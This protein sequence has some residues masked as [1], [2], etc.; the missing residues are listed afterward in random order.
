MVMKTIPLKIYR[1][2]AEKQKILDSAL[3]RY[4]AA[5]QYLLD[6][7]KPQMEQIKKQANDGSGFR[8]RRIGA[9]IPADSLKELNRFGVQPFKDSLKLDYANL[10]L[11]YFAAQ[12]RDEKAGYPKFSLDDAGLNREFRR[13]LEQ[14]EID[15]L[16]KHDMRSALFRLYP[17]YYA[18]HSMLFGR[19]AKSR[20]YCLLYD[21][22]KDR[23]YAKLYLMNVKDP[24]R[25][26]GIC[27]QST[28]RLRY[29]LPNGQMEYLEHDNRKERYLVLPLSY[30]AWQE[31]YLRMAL[32]DPKMIKT[33]RLE[34]RGKEYYLNV[35]MRI[36]EPAPKKTKAC[37]GIS[38]SLMGIV[39]Y[40]V[41][42][43]QKRM[44]GK[45]IIGEGRIGRLTKNDY[46]SV[47]NTLCKIAKMYDAQTVG[48]RL[49][50]KSDFLSF[51]HSRP[52]LTGGEYNKL[53]TMLGYKLAL[54]ALPRP[55]LVSPR[56]TFY[57]CPRC[58]KNTHKNRFNK[59]IFICVECGYTGKVEEVGTSNLAHI[60]GVYQSKKIVFQV[61]ELPDAYEFFHK[62]MGISF[63]TRK[64]AYLLCVNA[65]YEYLENLIEQKRD[66]KLLFSNMPIEKQK[67]RYSL[68]QR[69]FHVKSLRDEIVILNAQE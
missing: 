4:H 10:I 66:Q 63:Q 27:R 13:L 5:L 15:K 53:I 52:V 60:L 56:G 35:S 24:S 37:L 61:R 50:E 21:E 18:T 40:A 7:T 9:A 47:T 57:T 12:K 36:V 33:A 17:K 54:S 58:G 11:G 59:T 28:S 22:R 16:S 1:P 51:E 46:H 26:G 29:L 65:F 8:T 3:A 25:R 55:V 14:F 64:Q 44:I 43:E 49:G 23:F 62:E 6:S 45:G 48:Y 68:Y 69:L 32:A 39:S 34:K 2:T 31:R 42:D 38:R 19:Y 30:G 67:K 20:D 41:S